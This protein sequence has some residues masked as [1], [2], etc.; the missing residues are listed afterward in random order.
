MRTRSKDLLYLDIYQFDKLWL[1]EVKVVLFEPTDFQCETNS[2]IQ[3]FS[4]GL[5]IRTFLAC[6]WS[7]QL[8]AKEKKNGK[9]SQGR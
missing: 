4:R 7:F 5:I 6:D 2:H 1:K 9:T 3:I 8:K